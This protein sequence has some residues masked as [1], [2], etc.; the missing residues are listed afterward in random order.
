VEL[1]ET[2]FAKNTLLGS[3]ARFFL[4]N[5]KLINPTTFRFLDPSVDTRLALEFRQPLLRYFWG[6]PDIAR[7]QRARTLAKAAQ[8]RFFHLKEATA[9][10]AARA[11]L[12]LYY[13]QGLAGIRKRGVEDAK[14]LLAKYQDKRRYGLVESSDLLQAEASVKLQET[15]LL[16]AESQL[17][18]AQNA[19]QNAVFRAG[20]P[21]DYTIA[22]PSKLPPDE[23][24]D[25][26]RALERRGDLKAARAHSQSLDWNARVET[27]DA[28]PDLS[29]SASY[30]SAG[31]ASN[32]NRAWSD[33]GAFNHAVKS[34]GVSLSVSLGQKKERLTRKAAAL[35]A[36]AARA[37][38]AAA[39][40]SARHEIDDAALALAR[41]RQRLELSRRLVELE[42]K[43]Y[44]AEEE[45]FKRG[46]SSTDL[47]LRFQQDIRRG[48]AELLRA[49]VDE[50]LARLEL[51]RASGRL[52]EGMGL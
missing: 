10:A 3:E 11:Y 30:A 35:K 12:E 28:L 40:N 4:R 13:F 20:Q 34:A 16:L 36:Q 14:A 49:E 46:R 19:L 15:E 27:L 18:K 47:L 1:W 37:E 17:E 50:A 9:L 22:P 45:N 7:R 44:A 2:G 51:A 48:R 24:E 26:A 8:G 5:E 38:L 21:M 42:E 31:L 41:L 25:P 33:L 39:E 6:R 23:A 52:L 29:L 32:Y 43:K